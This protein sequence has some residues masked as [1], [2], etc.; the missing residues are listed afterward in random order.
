MLTFNF[1]V[2]AVAMVAGPGPANMILLTVGL[3]YGIRYSIK[4]LMAV[5]VSK[6]FIIWPIGLGILGLSNYAP[7]ILP[8]LKIVS[9]FYIIWLS[10]KILINNPADGTVNSVPGFFYGLLVHPLNPKAWLMVTASFASFSNDDGT[11]FYQTAQFATIFFIVQA[12]FHTMWLILGS[13]I[14]VLL[15]K[16]KFKNAFVFSLSSLMLL[17]VLLILF[18]N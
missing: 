9:I 8:I 3:K 5:I 17:S 6:Q 13:K 14:S 15:T 11:T 7:S 16:N 2:F 10:W 18:T 4:F 12:F 1:I